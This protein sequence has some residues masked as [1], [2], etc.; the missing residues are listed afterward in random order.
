MSYNFKQ[1]SDSQRQ[2][3]Y[4]LLGR[5]TGPGGF[6]RTSPAL[7]ARLKLWRKKFHEF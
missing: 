2:I 6:S 1:I 3:N 7:D 5:D 4:N